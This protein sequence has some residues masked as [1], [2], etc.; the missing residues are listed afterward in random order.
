MIQFFDHGR[1]TMTPAHAI[2]PSRWDRFDLLAVDTG[3]LRLVIES[4]HELEL[5]TGTGVVIY[6]HTRFEGASITT[7]S[8]VTVQH[9]GFDRGVKNAAVP[10]PLRRLIGRKR[11]YEPLRMRGQPQV[12]A[13]ID[14]AIVLAFEPQTPWL[15]DARVALLTLIFSRLDPLDSLSLPGGIEAWDS[16]DAWLRTQLHRPITV[17]HMAHQL[18]L[19]PGHFSVRFRAYMGTSPARHLHRLRMQEAMRRLRETREPIKAIA[20]KLGYEELPNF[21]RAFRK[22]VGHTPAAYRGRYKLRG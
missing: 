13:D 15:H 3:R 9:F 12:Q 8:V 2:P 17:A 4:K 14:R 22:A 16:L 6:P 19:S 11:G 1:N 7:E 10:L 20:E 5:E 18:G 21:Y